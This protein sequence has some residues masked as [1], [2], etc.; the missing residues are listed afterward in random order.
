[1]KLWVLPISVLV[2]VTYLF[3]DMSMCIIPYLFSAFDKDTLITLR[4][5]TL[6]IVYHW[7]LL[8]LLC[9]SFIFF[10]HGTKCCCLGT[11]PYPIQWAPSH[12]EQSFLGLKLP[13][14]SFCPLWPVLLVVA[15]YCPSLVHVIGLYFPY[16]WQNYGLGMLWPKGWLIPWAQNGL[17]M[18]LANGRSK[19]LHLLFP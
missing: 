11:I 16:F 19:V 18:I 15:C 14:R 8:V 7:L 3:I 13:L 9:L 1:M 12:R 10:N 17:P 6:P 5:C 4:S 2:W